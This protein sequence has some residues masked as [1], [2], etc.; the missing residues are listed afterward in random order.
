ML[1]KKAKRK[2]REKALE[3][4]RRL[5]SLQ[6]RRELKAAGIHLKRRKRK[7]KY[8]D[9]NA[10]IPFQRKAPRG[11]YDTTDDDLRA[12]GITYEARS[13]FRPTFITDI[14]GERRDDVEERERKKDAQR[15]KLIRKYN[16]PEAM[17]RL[18]QLNDVVTINKRKKMHLSTP[19]LSEEQLRAISRHGMSASHEQSTAT[20][21]LTA[22]LNVTDFTH[23]SGRP[24]TGVFW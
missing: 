6:K 10:E 18:N 11:F 5:A 22:Q 19:V 20:A 16:L 3:E 2:A 4:A 21:A 15:Q 9:Y 14:E 23:G 1:G 7:T 12:R 8:V 24:G 13:R 17:L